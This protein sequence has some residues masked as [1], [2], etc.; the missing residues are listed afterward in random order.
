MLADGLPVAGADIYVVA[1][2]SGEEM[3]GR[4]ATTGA[5]GRFSHPGVTVKRQVLWVLGDPIYDWT[6]RIHHADTWHGGYSDGRI[7]RP[8]RTVE[9]ACDLKRIF[10]NMACAVPPSMSAKL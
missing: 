10:N 2:A 5:D 7:G 1:K 4:I 6:L 9:L 3:T 8:P